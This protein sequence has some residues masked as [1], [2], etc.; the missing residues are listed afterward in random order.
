MAAAIIP[1]GVVFFS[2]K[3]HGVSDVVARR[4]RTRLTSKVVIAGDIVGSY[5]YDDHEGGKDAH[6]N[7]D[8][9]ARWER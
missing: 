9:A 8:G 5:W 1:G 6:F 2:E 4:G 7:E 3:G